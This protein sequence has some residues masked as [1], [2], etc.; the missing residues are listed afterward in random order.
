MPSGNEAG[1]NELWLN[2]GSGHFTPASGGPAGGQASTHTA[3]WGDVDGDG[4]LDLFVGAYATG[5]RRVWEVRGEEE[6]LRE[7]ERAQKEWGEGERE[8]WLPRC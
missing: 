6:E 8:C 3:S 4:D 2:D 1:G 5:E 7:G